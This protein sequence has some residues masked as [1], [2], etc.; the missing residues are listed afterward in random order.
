MVK[1][2]PDFFSHHSPRLPEG[3]VYREDLLTA[4]EE[5]GLVSFLKDLPFKEFE[6]QGFLGK[7]RVVS[8]GWRYD[9]KVRELQRA[10][11]LPLALSELRAKVAAFSATYEESWQQV[12]V[13]EYP[14][15]AAIG[16]HRDRPEFGDV[17]GISLLSSCTFRFRRRRHPSWERTSLT[18]DPRSVYLLSGPAREE[19]QHSIPAGEKLRYSITFRQLKARGRAR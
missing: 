7:R 1:H 16:W 11:A 2:Q 5:M 17:A 3:F 14:P 13:T 19:W 18:V 9:F 12:L 8:F 6:Y 10:E 15:G 4:D